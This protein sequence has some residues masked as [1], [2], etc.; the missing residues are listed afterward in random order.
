MS[1]FRWFPWTPGMRSWCENEGKSIYMEDSSRFCSSVSQTDIRHSSQQF[2]QFCMQWSQRLKRCP[3]I[4][5]RFIL[6]APWLFFVERG[7]PDSRQSSLHVSS[8]KGDPYLVFYQKCRLLEF[9]YENNCVDEGRLV[10]KLNNLLS[11][12]R[13]PVRLRS[14]LEER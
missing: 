3:S 4:S 1:F 9:W 13:E 8:G 7:S 11:L 5:L 12:K 10:E 6:N 2:Q 14:A